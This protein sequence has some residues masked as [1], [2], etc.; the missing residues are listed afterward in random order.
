MLPTRPRLPG[1]LFF[2]LVLVG[3]SVFLLWQA[4]GISGFDSL[5]SAGAYPMVA[6]AVMVVCAVLA[7]RHTWSAPLETAADGETLVAQFVRRIGPPMLVTFVLAIAVYMWLMERA[8]FVLSSYAFLVVSMG[9]LGS[10]KWVLNLWVSAL[11]LAAIY[12]VFQT[13]FSV[14]LPSGTWL[15]GVLK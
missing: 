2:A 7:T 12:L 10:R 4:Y 14:V 13:A 1:E 11:A 3:L 6:A 9:I 15:Q 5:T 8:G